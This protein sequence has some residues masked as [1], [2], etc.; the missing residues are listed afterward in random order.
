MSETG[1]ATKAVSPIHEKTEN[2]NNCVGRLASVVGDLE[3]RLTPIISSPSPEPEETC[4]E[5]EVQ[6]S[7]PLD[8]LLAGLRIR[9]ENQVDRIVGIMGRLQI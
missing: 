3:K 4:K 8:D 6:A 2:L 1:C 5:P 9:L 7:C